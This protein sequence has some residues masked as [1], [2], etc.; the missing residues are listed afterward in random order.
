ML[1]FCA[2][3]HGSHKAASARLRALVAARAILEKPIFSRYLCLDPSKPCARQ[4]ISVAEQAQCWCSNSGQLRSANLR[5][6]FAL[7]AIDGSSVA[8]LAGNHLIR[9]AGKSSDFRRYRI[10]WLVQ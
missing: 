10:G 2:G 6:K 7:R 9:N 8:P 3:V 1:A 4:S 5:S